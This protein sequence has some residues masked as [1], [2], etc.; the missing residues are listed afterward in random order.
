MEDTSMNRFVLRNGLIVGLI[1]ISA[2]WLV[3]KVF[4]IDH[5]LK[6][7]LSQQFI[8]LVL[9]P[10]TLAY[11]YLA[12][13]VVEYRRHQ[14]GSVLP[15]DRVFKLMFFTMMVA[16]VL[17]GCFDFYYTNYMYPECVN[18]QLARAEQT[19]R[20]SGLEEDEINNSLSYQ[21]K[22]LADFVWFLLSQLIFRALINSTISL[23][24]AIVLRREPKN[25]PAA[26]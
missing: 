22:F 14:V 13:R 15:F 4:G 2:D 7:A 20:Q 5:F 21:R 18:E 23:L 16:A 10:M 1:L 24:F 3:L 6:A 19:L 26:V 17:S 8:W 12:V 9:I 11:V 25:P